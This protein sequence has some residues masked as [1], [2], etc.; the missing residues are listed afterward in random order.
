MELKDA[1]R[2]LILS[3][4][5]Q[6]LDNINLPNMLADFKAYEDMPA[7][8]FLV[9][10][11]LSE[12]VMQ[13]IVNI[14]NSG[15]EAINQLLSLKA[16]LVN[17]YGFRNEVVN[18]FVNGLIKAFGWNSMPT[19]DVLVET[20]SIQ[21]TT[22]PLQSDQNSEG[23]L[24]FKGIPI[25]GNPQHFIAQLEAKGFNTVQSYSYSDHSAG[26]TGS[27]AGVQNCIILVTGTPVSND[28]YSIGVIFPDQ[29]N[30]WYIL[31]SQY[32]S[33]KEKLTKK[34]GALQSF[35]YFSEPYYEGDGYEISAMMNGNGHFMSYIDT[36]EGRIA[37]MITSDCKICLFY[38]DSEGSKQKDKE[39]NS[40]SFED[41]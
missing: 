24:K 12:G 5:P 21:D 33:Y 18:Y 7:C 22:L 6:V 8:R 34:Y 16:D 31:K 13:N 1:L 14:Y 25:A 17:Q 36:Q 23:H 20:E 39:L 32:L 9:K 10:I 26:L 40:L 30:D 11:C 2:E 29:Y 41:I 3:K 4:G 15:E 28:V 19:D 38:N 37:V 35:E 27:F